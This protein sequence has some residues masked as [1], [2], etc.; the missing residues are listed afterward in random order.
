[1][2]NN[3]EISILIKRHFE[4]Q[5]FG[6]LATQSEGQ[7]YT[8]LVAFAEFANLRSLLF[9]TGRNT[10][11]YA[12]TLA[13]KKVALLV[14]NRKNQISDLRKAVAITALGRV[15]EVDADDKDKLSGIYLAK[16][17]LLKEFFHE[18]LNALM[19]VTVTEFFVATFE[20][21]RRVPIEDIG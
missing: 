20:G 10:R 7:P 12:N 17:P 1:M 9:V 2:E 16:H 8:N 3:F 21:V 14:D 15:E 5:R 11:K 18:P 6:V 13:S 4:E 19:K